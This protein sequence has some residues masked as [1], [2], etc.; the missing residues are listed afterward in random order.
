MARCVIEI[1]RARSSSSQHIL[2]VEMR[3][4]LMDLDEGC[5]KKQRDKNDTKFVGLSLTP[6]RGFP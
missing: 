1:E 3:G 5:E 6:L 2:K 4:L